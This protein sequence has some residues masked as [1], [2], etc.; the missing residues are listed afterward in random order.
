MP[1]ILLLVDAGFYHRGTKIRQ[2]A[3]DFV[4]TET[5][6]EHPCDAAI[7][8][9]QDDALGGKEA[10]HLR[11]DV[12]RVLRFGRQQ[13]QVK[14]VSLLVVLNC[15]NVESVCP[16]LSSDAGHAQARS[17]Q[18]L[19]GIGITSRQPDGQPGADGTRRNGSA[20]R[21]DTHDQHSHCEAPHLL[22]R[23]DVLGLAVTKGPIFLRN[24]DKVDEDIFLANLYALVEMVRQGLVEA[25]LQL[26]G[27]AAIQCD[28]KKD[29]IVRPLYAEILP[30]ERQ[31]RLRVFRDYLK[32]VMCRNIENVHQGL[33]KDIADLSTVLF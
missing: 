13:D 20:Q 31:A 12:Q 3:K 2:S 9:G 11:R 21:A 23:R 33:V 16:R 15:G 17:A 19:R 1:G 26:S 30:I 7:L 4:L 10:H 32:S 22:W 24:F 5:V 18:C 29:A 14:R 27:T 25:L 8:Y 6:R 28:L